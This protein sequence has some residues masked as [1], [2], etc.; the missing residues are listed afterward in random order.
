MVS[1]IKI[2][3][4]WFRTSGVELQMRNQIATDFLSCMNGDSLA[5]HFCA[6][7]YCYVRY[8]APEAIS[9]YPLQHLDMFGFSSISFRFLPE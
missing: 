9:A 7:Y 4:S 3:H 6:V 1:K 8:F 5:E 2:L